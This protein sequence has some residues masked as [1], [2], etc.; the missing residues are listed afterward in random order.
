VMG[1]RWRPDGCAQVFSARPASESPRGRKPRAT[2]VSYGDLS[3]RAAVTGSVFGLIFSAARQM[4]TAA[5]K[6][7]VGRRHLRAEP[8]NN[9]LLR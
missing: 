8:A 1:F 5:C 3:E 2:T 6:T 4:P 9:P 7:G